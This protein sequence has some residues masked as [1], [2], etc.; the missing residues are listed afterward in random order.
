MTEYQLEKKYTIAE[1]TAGELYF[2]ISAKRNNPIN[3]QIVYDGQDHAILVRSPDDKI[4]LD[5]INPQVRDKLRK[6]SQVI[7]VE[8]IMDNIKDSYCTIMHMV[9]K[10]PLDWSKIGLTTWEEASLAQ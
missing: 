6:A 9:D 3:P 1:G 4:I 7:V 10:I 2:F 8:S 5:Y